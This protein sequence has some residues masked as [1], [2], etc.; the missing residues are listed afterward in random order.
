MKIQTISPINNN[1]DGFALVTTMIMMVILTLIGVSATNTTV[2]ELMVA[3]NERLA[4]QRFLTADSGWKQGGPFLNTRATPPMVINM[5]DTSGGGGR[6]WT[7]EYYQIVRNFGDGDDGTLND[8]FSAGSEDGTIANIPY[9]YRMIYQGDDPAV[10]FGAG[11]RD[12]QYGIA[13]NADNTAEVATRIKKV[14]R[15]GY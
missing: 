8:D 5:T 2:F 10:M 1:E 3:G 13:C 6:D 12:F 15:V 4:S 9:W 14:F 11:Y 7:D